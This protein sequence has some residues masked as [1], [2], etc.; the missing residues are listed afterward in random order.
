MHDAGFYLSS[1]DQQLLF[2]GEDLAAARFGPSALY[3]RKFT[4]IPA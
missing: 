4:I 2:D 1:L 3:A